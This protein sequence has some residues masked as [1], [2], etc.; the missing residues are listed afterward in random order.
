VTNWNYRANRIARIGVKVAGISV[1]AGMGWWG[2]VECVLWAARNIEAS[3]VSSGAV[4]TPLCMAA[5]CAFLYWLSAEVSSVVRPRLAELAREK[6]RRH[7]V[8][9]GFPVDGA[10][11]R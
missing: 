10:W 5:V 2:I 9:R 1:A 8:R 11:R 4:L 3:G 7:L 6:G